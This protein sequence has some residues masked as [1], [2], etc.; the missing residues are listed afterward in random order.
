MGVFQSKPVQLATVPTDAIVPVHSLDDTP[1]FRSMVLEFTLRFDDVLDPLKLRESLAQLLEIGDWKK[2]GARLR[3]NKN[4][5]LE[6]HIPAQFTEERPPF[7][8][9]HVQY[10][11]SIEEHPLASKIPKNTPHPS[12]HPDPAIF[13][14]LARAPDTPT[15]IEDYI[16]SDRPQL[17]L[18]IVSF[19]DATLISITWPHTFIDAMG[20]AAFFNAWIQVLNGQSSFVLPLH[21]FSTDPLSN[22]VKTPTTTHETYILTPF[23]IKGVKFYF[24]IINYLL[25]LVIYPKEEAHSVCFPAST[26]SSLKATAVK[27]LEAQ[28][29]D[30][31]EKPFLSD[32]DI[33]TALW[34]RLAVLHLTPPPTSKKP[35]PKTIINISNAFGLRSILS[36]P[37]VILPKE[38]AYISNA[39]L[40]IFTLLPLND[41]IERPISWTANEVRRIPRR[42]LVG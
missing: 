41:L 39:V 8:Y 38:K 5:K 3:L 26:I 20:L 16:Y 37:P 13:R 32:G 27:E 40:S 4:G 19:T 2:L 22:L 36:S 21:G 6:Y 33:I 10:E 23:L 12:I 35:I 14:P 9:S 18:H 11:S 17:C 28:N 31:K 42:F 25:E 7:S 30:A 34:A 24:F 29:P 15:K 1:V